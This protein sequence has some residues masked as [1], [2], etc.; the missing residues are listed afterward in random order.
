MEGRARTGRHE[1]KGRDGTVSRT[2]LSG[3][4][5][6]IHYAKYALSIGRS[7]QRPLMQ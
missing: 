7:N 5:V 6:V 3:L 4:A 1:E 2:F